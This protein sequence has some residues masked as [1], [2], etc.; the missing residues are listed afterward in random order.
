MAFG[1][2]ADDQGLAGVTKL[3]ETAVAARSA[4]IVGVTVV[5]PCPYDFLEQ[6]WAVENPG[7]DSGTRRPVELRVRLTCSLRTWRSLR[8]TVLTSLCPEGP[9]TCTVPWTAL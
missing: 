3:V 8:R 9:H 6:Q 1:L 7:H 2:Y 5:D 4:R